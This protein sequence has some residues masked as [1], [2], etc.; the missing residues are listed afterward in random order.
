MAV[1]Q[2]WLVQYIEWKQPSREMHHLQ[3]CEEM[4]KQWGN[5]LIKMSLMME[6]L[7]IILWEKETSSLNH[8]FQKKFKP[9]SW[10]ICLSSYALE[11][12]W[13]WAFQWVEQCMLNYLGIQESWQI[14]IHT[15]GKQRN[16]HLKVEM[17]WQKMKGE[18]H[19]RGSSGCY[20]ENALAVKNKGMTS[21]ICRE[22]EH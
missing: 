17:R 8:Y 15:Q 22:Q 19:I 4:R 7:T 20:M 3:R 12:G 9:T 2:H 1:H 18:K 10:T 6:C 11:I 14:V 16:E 21:E 13:R 5:I